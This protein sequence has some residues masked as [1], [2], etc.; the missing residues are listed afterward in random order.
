MQEFLLA[1]NYVKQSRDIMHLDRISLPS[2]STKLENMKIIPARSSFRHARAI[3]DEQSRE[4]HTPQLI[5][6]AM[7]HLDDPH[8]DALIAMKDGVA[9]AHVGVLA[10]G[11]TG[12]IEDVFVSENFRRRGVGAIMMSR[13][14]EI[15][16]RSLFKHIMLGVAPDNDTAIRLYKK[17]GFRKIGDFVEFRNTSV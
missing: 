8:Y 13:A 3:Y 2:V 17:C 14:L 16:A 11:E 4:W 12:V 7:L 6:A 15:C 1:K 9:I 10:M 5:E